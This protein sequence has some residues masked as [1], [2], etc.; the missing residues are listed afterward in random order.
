MFVIVQAWN[1]LPSNVHK[2]RGIPERI[3][4]ALKHAV[5][6]CRYFFYLL[7]DSSVAIQMETKIFPV[8][9]LFIA[10]LTR[11]L[12]AHGRRSPYSWSVYTVHTCHLSWGYKY[13]EDASLNIV[14]ALIPVAYL[15]KL[16]YCV[17][18]SASYMSLCM[19]LVK[20]GNDHSRESY[21]F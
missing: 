2:T 14:L 18:Q 9:P 19:K 21:W 6:L 17:A 15:N 5:S 12:K 7:C 4:L 20:L 16:Y 8:A 13:K 3:G 10:E 11:G 1:N